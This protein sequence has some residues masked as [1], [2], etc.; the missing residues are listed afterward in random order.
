MTIYN[1]LSEFV[2]FL[3]KRLKENAPS[4]RYVGADLGQMEN[5]PQ[6]GKPPLSFPAVLFEIDDTSYMQLGQNTQIGESILQVR[7]CQP[8]YSGTAN[9]INPD[10]V[11]EV[12]LNY[13]ET[14]QEVFIAL[15]GWSCGA[16]SSMVRVS[17]KT[18]KRN[19]EYRVKTMRF[20][21]GVEDNTADK[22]ISIT[23]PDIELY[24]PY[25]TTP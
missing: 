5:Y 20:S 7:V 13:M 17:N 23:V 15:Q 16:V 8:S 19:D 6:G 10:S 3:I 1:P 4:L 25:I 11:N 14:E 21:F 12:A 9:N 2:L 22:P 18:E 24:G